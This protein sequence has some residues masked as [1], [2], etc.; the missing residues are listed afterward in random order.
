MK[1]IWLMRFDYKGFTKTLEY[2][3]ERP[4]RH[5]SIAVN[6]KLVAYRLDH[7]FK[8]D[9]GQPRVEKIDFQLKYAAYPDAFYEE[10]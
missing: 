3:G 7:N 4:P 2:I 9:G 10:Q 1:N 8:G 6:R 5:Y